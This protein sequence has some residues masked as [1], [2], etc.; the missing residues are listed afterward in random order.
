MSDLF[1]EGVRDLYDLPYTLFEAIRRGLVYLSFE[2]W[3][4][5]DRPPRRI[6]KDGEKLMAHAAAVKARRKS[7]VDG[8]GAIEDPVENAFKPV[9]G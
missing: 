9:V 2:E 5:E 1:P 7:E 6:W 3:P 4:E 8:P